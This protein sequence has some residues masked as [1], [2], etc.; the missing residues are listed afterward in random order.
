MHD[1]V[2]VISKRTGVQEVMSY[3][4]KNNIDVKRL[5]IVGGGEL[6]RWLQ[7]NWKTVW[8]T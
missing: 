7:K 5:M 3:S 2:F 6:V 1:L 8:T 4:G